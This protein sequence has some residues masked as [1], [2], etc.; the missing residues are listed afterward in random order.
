MHSHVAR[1]R[2]ADAKRKSGERKEEKRNGKWERP[3]A[4]LS[5]VA[6]G[7]ASGEG[8]WWRVSVSVSVRV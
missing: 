5:L 8:E 3:G 7:G 2:D 4:G 1:S 6:S